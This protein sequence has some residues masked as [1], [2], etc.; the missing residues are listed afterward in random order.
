MIKE[1]HAAVGAEIE[2]GVLKIHTP[3]A[4]WTSRFIEPL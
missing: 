2:R 1:L 3:L 4:R